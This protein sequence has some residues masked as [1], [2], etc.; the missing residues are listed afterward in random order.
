MHLLSQPTYFFTVETGL[1]L[2]GIS[3]SLISAHFFTF[4]FAWNS[5][6]LSEIYLVLRTAI[7]LNICL[8]FGTCH[9][10]VFSLQLFKTFFILLH[11]KL[12]L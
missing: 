5:F 12:P 6:S 1:L 3:D 9:I 7:S 4:P 10:T 2:K 11:Y 8:S